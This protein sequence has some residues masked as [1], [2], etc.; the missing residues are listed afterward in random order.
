MKNTTVALFALTL[1]SVFM[2]EMAD[3]ATARMAS[4]IFV[5]NQVSILSNYVGRLVDD[6]APVKRIA[7]FIIPVNRE[8]PIG[9]PEFSA[10]THYY[11]GVAVMYNGSPYR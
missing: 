4:E 6:R 5:M 8:P 10:G 2:A 7:M 11:E 1:S 9:Y 3:G